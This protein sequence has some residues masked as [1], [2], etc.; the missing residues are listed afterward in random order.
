MKVSN[1]LLLEPAALNPR[2]VKARIKAK[3]AKTENVS[4]HM[5]LAEPSPD[6]GPATSAL[7]NN[8][9]IILNRMCNTMCLPLTNNSPLLQRVTPWPG[10]IIISTTLFFMSLHLHFQSERY[11]IVPHRA[12]LCRYDR[13]ESEDAVKKVPCNLQESQI[14][15]RQR[16]IGAGWIMGTAAEVNSVLSFADFS[17]KAHDLHRHMLRVSHSHVDL[18]LL[19][20]EV[21]WNGD[22][23]CS[24]KVRRSTS[25][26]PRFFKYMATGDPWDSRY[27]ASIQDILEG[28]GEKAEMSPRVRKTKKKKKRKKITGRPKVTYHE[29]EVVTMTVTESPKRPGWCS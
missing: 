11:C 26:Q 10:Y 19:L 7:K 29:A 8:V 22:V 13:R 17:C 23:D 20:R 27:P 15:K 5:D 4:S 25:Q 9:P 12:E 18:D 3:N 16:Q 28:Y 24:S 6:S 2:L 1:S 14:I 21:D